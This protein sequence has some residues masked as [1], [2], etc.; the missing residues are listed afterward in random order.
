MLTVSL[1]TR[2]SQASDSSLLIALDTANKTRP[3]VDAQVANLHSDGC[4]LSHFD[5]VV[6]AFA[7][8]EFWCGMTATPPNGVAAGRGTAKLWLTRDAHLVEAVETKKRLKGKGL[9]SSDETKTG[10][11]KAIELY[12]MCMK[13]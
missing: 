11:A 12:N 8:D 13:S 5:E 10:S 4:Q 3:A 9:N 2:N 7:C 6:Q 1:I